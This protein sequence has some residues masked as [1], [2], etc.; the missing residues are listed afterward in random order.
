M[1]ENIRE[2]WG[3]FIIFAGT[4]ICVRLLL[5]MSLLLPNNRRQHAALCAK[6]IP[7]FSKENKDWRH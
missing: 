5:R 3:N 6:R 2:K 1:I 4:E 7:P